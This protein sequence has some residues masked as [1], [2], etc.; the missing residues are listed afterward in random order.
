MDIVHCLVQYDLIVLYKMTVLVDVNS[1][2]AVEVH[3]KVAAV[4]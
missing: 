2:T 1:V 3:S 4:Y